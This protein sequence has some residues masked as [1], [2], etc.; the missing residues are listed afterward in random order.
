M[1]QVLEGSFY[2]QSHEY[3]RVPT[4]WGLQQT[5]LGSGQR[6]ETGSGILWSVHR[7][8]RLLRKFFKKKRTVHLT[9]LLLRQGEPGTSQYLPIM[10]IC[11]HLFYVLFTGCVHIYGQGG[12]SAAVIDPILHLETE[13]SPWA[14]TAGKKPY[15]W[16]VDKS[17]QTIHKLRYLD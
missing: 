3:C 9:R 4:R 17:S 8:T 10:L 16:V 2:L 5:T 14:V 15:C 12:Q 6:Q 11:F 7:W 1:C 13:F